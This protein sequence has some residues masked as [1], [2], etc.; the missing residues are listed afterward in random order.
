MNDRVAVLTE[1][2]SSQSFCGP[3]SASTKVNDAF[4]QE[5]QSCGY[6]G[7]SLMCISLVV[8]EV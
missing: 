2:S 6:Q 7:S 3:R 4:R 5:Y 1:K 8:G